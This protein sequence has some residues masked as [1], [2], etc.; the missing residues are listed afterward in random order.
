MIIR[1]F[2][3]VDFWLCLCFQRIG[4]GKEEHTSKSP[5]IYFEYTG[6]NIFWKDHCIF[7]LIANISSSNLFSILFKKEKKYKYKSKTKCSKY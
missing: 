5:G 4:H 3:K 2:F 7:L 1:F 6:D